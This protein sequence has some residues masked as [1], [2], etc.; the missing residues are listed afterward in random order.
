MTVNLHGDIIFSSET[1]KR[2]PQFQSQIIQGRKENFYEE[3]I[4][5]YD[6]CSR[7]TI[8]RWLWS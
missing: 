8:T 5:G 1:R 6:F 4:C 2:F 7:S 3:I